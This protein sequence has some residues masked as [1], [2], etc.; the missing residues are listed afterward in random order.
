[1]LWYGHGTN[2]H[3]C[4][5]LVYKGDLDDSIYDRH[6][7]EQ[8]QAGRYSRPMLRRG[9]SNSYISTT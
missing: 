3:S 1:M 4:I 5:S 9:K 7:R 6:M 8:R 2:K